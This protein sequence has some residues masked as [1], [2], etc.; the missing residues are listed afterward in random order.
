MTTLT[1]TDP[2]DLAA[3]AIKL[4]HWMLGEL[5]AI[6]EQRGCD[7]SEHIRRCVSLERKL[8]EDPQ[9]HIVATRSDGSTFEAPDTEGAAQP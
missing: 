9:T 7:V 8:F 6:A 5:R 3:I 4:P 2:D 1:Q